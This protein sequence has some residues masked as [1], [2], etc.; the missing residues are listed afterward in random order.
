MFFCVFQF[1][2]TRRKYNFLSFLTLVCSPDIFIHDDHA[3]CLNSAHF[4]LT[5]TVC[6]YIMNGKKIVR[7]HMMIMIKSKQILRHDF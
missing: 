2:D 6:M 7:I 3:Q 4:P 5:H 1:S